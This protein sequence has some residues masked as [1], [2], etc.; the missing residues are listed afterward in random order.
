[1]EYTPRDK[2]IEDDDMSRF[3]L[4]GKLNSAN[5]SNYT[6]ETLIEIYSIEKTTGR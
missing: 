6:I 2:N 5:E 4:D 3:Q 1:M